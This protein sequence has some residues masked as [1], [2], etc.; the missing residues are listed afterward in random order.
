MSKKMKVNAEEEAKPAAPEEL[1]ALAPL[2][3][4]Q[5]QELKERAAKA[6]E[7]WDR[8]LRQAADLEN[9]RKRAARE[10]LEAVTF[11]NQALVQK[12]IPTLDALEMA[13][14][15]GNPDPASQSLRA[16]ILMVSNQL[17][18]TLAEAGL[19]EVDATGKTFDPAIHE[20]VSQEET[21]QVP[22]G[23][24]VRQLRKGYKFHNRLIRPAGVIV[25]KKPA[26]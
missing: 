7:N 12:L 13:L 19:E 26:P 23:R 25:A 1:P 10:R 16:G 11:A 21:A 3:A 14:A 18:S 6:D 24:V 20:A 22:E 2:T 17:K 15:A 9:Y 8:F 5:I 4:G